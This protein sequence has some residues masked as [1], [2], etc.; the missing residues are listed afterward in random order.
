MRHTESVRSRSAAVVICPVRWMRSAVFMLGLCAGAAGG[1]ADNPATT[2]QVD[3]AANRRP[4]NPNIYG[5]NWAETQDLVALNAPLNRSGGNANSRYNWQLDAHATGADWYFETYPDSAGTPSGWVDSF[6]DKTRA[7]GN[8][9]EPMV[10]M[11]MLD[12]LANL[13]PGRTTLAG[14]SVKKYGAQERTDPWNSDAGNGISAATGKPITG[15]DPNDTGV[16]N[17]PAIQK[18]WVQHLVAKYGPATSATGIK[19][20]ILDNEYSVWRATHR[21]VHPDPVTYDEIW[22]KIVAYA[23]AIRAVDPT[24]KICAGEEYSWFAMYYSGFDQANGTSAANSDYNTHGRVYFYPWLLQKIRAHKE[25]TGVQLVDVITVHGYADG[26][27]DDDQ[28][29]TQ[30]Q[31][32]RQTRILWDPAYQDPFWYGDIGIEGRSGRI[33]HWLPTLKKWVDQYCP[34]LQIGITEYNWGNET[35][36]NGAT[37]QADVL[38]IYGREGVDL[39]TRWGVAKK[40][41]S[42]P[43]LY[44]VT[45]LASQIYRNY[46]GKNSTFG[47]ISISTADANPDKL[48]AFAALRSADGA[49]TVMVINKQQGS[50]PVTVNLANFTAGAAAQAWQINSAAQKEIARLADVAVAGNALTTTVPSQ[51]ITLLVVP[52]GTTTVSAP[53]PTPVAPTVTPVPPTPTSPAPSTPSGGGAG[54]SSGGGG[55][56]AVGPFFLAAL[57][58]LCGA[59]WSLRRD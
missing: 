50:T 24:A 12:Y 38:G 25:Q 7:A 33:V 2:V 22:E 1:A 40:W 23:S 30:L 8:G 46:D 47:D 49:L 55:G 51:S 32:N 35:N 10:T 53:Q 17:T 56:G 43:T 13:G 19:Y 27:A 9:A 39:A 58:L 31:R 42:N 41:D 5:V 4:I 44:Y 48:S 54:G 21:D 14:F 11:P 16:P 59:R 36:L 3:A 29:A 20:Y 52:A 34:G 15:N 28:P 57:A 18:A 45:H 26:P 6:V 37:T